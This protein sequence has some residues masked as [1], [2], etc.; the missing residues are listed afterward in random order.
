MTRS[1]WMPWPAVERRRPRRRKPATVQAL[2]RRRVPRRRPGGWRPSTRQT[3][4][5]SQPI[6]RLPSRPETRARLGGWGAIAAD[7]GGPI[8]SIRPEAF[9]DVR[10]VHEAH[11]DA[12]ADNRLAGLRAAPDGCALPKPD[13]QQTPPRPSRSAS[14]ASSPDL[15]PRS[16]APVATPRSRSHALLACAAPVGWRAGRGAVL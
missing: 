4:T 13:A 6:V 12:H 10:I 3:C 14:P 5:Y 15:R 8:R 11:R 2:S 16:S 1:M 7:G 9:F